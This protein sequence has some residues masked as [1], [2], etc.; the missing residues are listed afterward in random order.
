[1]SMTRWIL[2]LL[3][4]P[5]FFACGQ[6]DEQKTAGEKS[7][8]EEAVKEAVTKE[9]KMYEG[10]KA[11]VDKIQKEAQEKREKEAK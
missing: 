10:A 5:I 8:V 2:W 1:M 9:F 6:K 11:A 3:L 7:K 4:L